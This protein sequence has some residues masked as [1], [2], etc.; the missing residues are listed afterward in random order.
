MYASLFRLP[1]ITS[2]YVEGP[3]KTCF[4]VM[5]QLTKLQVR[6]KDLPPRST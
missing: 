2:Q 1:N 4:V 5:S 6:S 3:V